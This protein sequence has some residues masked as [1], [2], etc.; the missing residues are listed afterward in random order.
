MSPWV[1]K[2][3]STLHLRRDEFH[4][5]R[6]PSQDDAREDMGGNAAKTTLT[7]TYIDITTDLRQRR[8]ILHLT[9]DLA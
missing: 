5:A 7:Y 4:F 3:Q 1:Q 8:K 6:Y 2:S 9:N